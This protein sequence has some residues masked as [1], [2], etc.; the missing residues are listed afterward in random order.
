MFLWTA[1][2][3]CGI[4][5]S[6]RQFRSETW[7]L[8]LA[9]KTCNFQKRLRPQIPLLLQE[10]HV[11]CHDRLDHLS[12]PSH[13]LHSQHRRNRCRFPSVFRERWL[14]F[15]NQQRSLVLRKCSKTIL[16]QL[17][18]SDF[19]PRW[20]RFALFNTALIHWVEH[21]KEQQDCCFAVKFLHPR[22]V[23]QRSRE[24]VERE[25]IGGGNTHGNRCVV[26][27]ICLK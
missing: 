13:H 11:L 3:L 12:G 25:A 21:Q 24:F 2:L 1:L 27:W 9:T 14:V 18:S 26:R 16:S 6:S 23:L 20:P 19:S 4:G 5:E 8:C 7:F 17:L 22:R 15:W 10:K